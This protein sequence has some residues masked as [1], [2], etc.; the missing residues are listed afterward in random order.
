MSHVFFQASLAILVLVGFES[1]TAL[2]SEA[3]NPKDI[4]HA[5]ILSLVIQGAFAYLLGFFG[6]QAWINSN[7][8]FAMAAASP[9]PVGDIVRTSTD[10]LFGGGGF[11]VML[12]V[13]AAVAAAVLGTTLACLNTG[14]RVTYAISRDTEAPEPLGK[15]NPRYGTPAIGTW[16]LTLVSALIGAFGVLSLKNLTTVMLL[17]NFGTFLLYGVTCLV[18][19]FALSRERRSILTKYMVPLA[20]FVANM[21]MMGVV[22]W[23][24]FVGSSGTQWAASAAIAITAVWMLIGLAYFAVNSRSKPSSIFPFPGKERPEDDV[25]KFTDIKPSEAN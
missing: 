12:V 1:I 18:A 15:L 19:L 13:A 8:T 9:G 11:V 16:V 6:I 25:K 20:G 4:P 14:V 10:A 3:K 24:G 17:S 5:I 23:L 21:V 22:V 7:Y 2:T